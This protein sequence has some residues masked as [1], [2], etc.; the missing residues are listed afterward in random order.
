MIPRLTRAY[1]E[2]RRYI[3]GIAIHLYEKR[4]DGSISILSNLI[5][6]TYGLNEAIPG[7]SEIVLPTETAQ[8]LMDSLWQCGLRPSEG[9]GSAGSLRATEN[10][11]KDLQSI[12]DRLLKMVEEHNN[13]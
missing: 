11:L 2:N 6:E 10:H 1:A 12:N 9:S 3:D 13:G 8:E 4:P 5:F 7:N